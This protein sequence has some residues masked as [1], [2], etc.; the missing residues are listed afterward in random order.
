MKLGIERNG[1]NFI[2]FQKSAKFHENASLQGVLD[3]KDH[4]TPCR[5]IRLYAG[6]VQQWYSSF[7]VRK[8]SMQQ[9]I[10]QRMAG[11]LAVQD[12]TNFRNSRLQR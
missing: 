5:T 9:Y 7:S 2:S 6:L 11:I 10:Q 1:A 4:K 8:S 3:F 12:C